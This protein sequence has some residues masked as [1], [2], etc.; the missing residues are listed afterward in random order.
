MPSERVL[1]EG[2]Y[3]GNTAMGEYRHPAPFKP[4]LEEKIVNTVMALAA[5]V[6]RDVGGGRVA[7]AL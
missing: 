6:E 7:A 1:A 4:G 2:D 3:E 5:T